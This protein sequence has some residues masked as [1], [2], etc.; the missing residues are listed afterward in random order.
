MSGLLQRAA[1]IRKIFDS[2]PRNLEKDSAKEEIYSEIDRIIGQLH[3]ETVSFSTDFS[4]I[5]KSVH[6]LFSGKDGSST[7]TATEP[8]VDTFFP[9]SR[10]SFGTFTDSFTR[11][12]ENPVAS[13]GWSQINATTQI[14]SNNLL[15]NDAANNLAAIKRSKENYVKANL[16]VELY[17][18]TEDV[19]GN[20]YGLIATYGTDGTGTVQ[21]AAGGIGVAWN[22]AGPRWDF[23]VDGTNVANHPFTEPDASDQVYL[24]IQ[25]HKSKILLKV[26]NVTDGE[27]EP[28]T[29]VEYDNEAD[30][31]VF[32]GDLLVLGSYN[33][34]STH[35][36]GVQT[37]TVS[38]VDQGFISK[39]TVSGLTVVE[40]ITGFT[41]IERNDAK[42][43]PLIF[44]RDIKLKET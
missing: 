17:L 3:A 33:G 21:Q 4:V 31:T 23:Y 20:Q 1:A 38:P 6:F 8:T 16:P 11:A 42:D 25:F 35:S 27:S 5:R 24:R 43:K 19:A 7:E 2:R 32:D 13:N 26:W 40:Q 28:N 10:G 34:G 29:W 36:T 22:E 9:V 44:Q 41:Q 15:M 14:T 30:F 12:N 37:M 39:G 18:E